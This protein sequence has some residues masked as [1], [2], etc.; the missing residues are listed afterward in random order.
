MSPAGRPDNNLVSGDMV[1]KYL[2]Q[3]AED[4]GLKRHIRF[5]S[6]VS[7]LKRNPAGG[8]RLTVNGKH[9]DAAKVM[10]AAGTTTQVNQPGFSITDDAIPVIHAVDIA[11]SVVEFE[12]PG[13]KH[14]VLMGASKSA[15]DAAYLLSSMG[16]KITWV[17]RDNGSGP[18]SIMPSKMLGQNITTLGASRLM[19]YLS[20]S[21]MTTDTWLGSFFHRTALGRWLTKASW[22]YITRQA[23][24][25][26]GFGGKAGNVEGLKPEI[27]DNSCF[28]CESSL[29]LI[30]MEDFWSTLKAGD[31]RIVRDKVESA[32]AAGV[33]LKKT[34][35]RIEADFVVCA[36]GWGDHFSFFTPE[37]KEEM[38]IPPYGAAKGAPTSTK[39]RADPW[40]SHDRAAD[41][42][43][44][45]K[46]PQLAAG[47]KDLRGWRRGPGREV[48]TR[49]WRLYN[50]VVPLAV[51]ARGDRS[52][53]VLGQIHTTQTPTISEVQSLWAVAYMLGDIDLPG[54]A[55]M[56]REIAEWNAWTRRRYAAVGERSPCALFDWISYLDR[57]LGDL[58]VES[59]RNGNV[60]VD[61]FKP[62]GP[63]SYRGVVDEYM[64]H[65]SKRL[66]AESPAL[67]N[68]PMVGDDSSSDSA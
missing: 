30:T 14:F 37:L 51:A 48:T 32:D 56:V 55:D 58:G 67:A 39:H 47:P 11:K 40:A 2:D 12:K 4:N 46:I 7:E 64:A 68:V 59:R 42:L 5:N 27:A 15:Y 57:L 29:G 18:M 36:T 8:W 44:A 35:E 66:R 60:I 21:L 49:R 61:F 34:G 41:E 19:N 20:P 24:K 43:L 62:Y 1:W 50:R 16:K 26:A 13:N 45:R 33:R 63:H 9:I 25:A 53:V 31:V 3:F 6:W 17:I 23:N 10:C 52:L 54:E 65:R 38:G 28:W 22:G